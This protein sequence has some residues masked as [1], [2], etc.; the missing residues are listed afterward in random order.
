MTA[1]TAFG[2]RCPKGHCRVTVTVMVGSKIPT[3]PE[4]NAAMVPDQEASGVGVKV[5]CPRCKALFGMVTS[6]RC[7]TCGGE[8]QTAP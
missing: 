6:D 7:P 5:Y 1:G 2:Y 3:C 4:C 8:F